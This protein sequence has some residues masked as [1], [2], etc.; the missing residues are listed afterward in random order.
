MSVCLVALR[1]ASAVFNYMLRGLL[2]VL[3]EYELEGESVFAVFITILV[4]STVGSH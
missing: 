3:K 1:T 4:Y 2:C